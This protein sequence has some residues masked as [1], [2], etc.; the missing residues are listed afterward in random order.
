MRVV[1]EIGIVEGD[2][3][4]FEI[5]NVAEGPPEGQPQF[6]ELDGLTLGISVGLLDR[7]QQV[8][9]VHLFKA[10]GEEMA[11]LL[12]EPGLSGFAE[13]EDLAVEVQLRSIDG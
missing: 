13:H 9:E 6:V 3:Q 4:Q 10:A 1:L 12:I 7:E 5:E 11:Q 2:P 8:V